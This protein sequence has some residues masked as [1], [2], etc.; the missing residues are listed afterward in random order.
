M[1][2]RVLSGILVTRGI[3]NGNTTI[4]FG[5]RTVTGSPGLEAARPTMV[6]DEGIY[7]HKPC[8]MV[9]IREIKIKETEYTRGKSKDDTSEI[10]FLRISTQK[11]DRE[12][13]SIRWDCS[14]GSEI[15]EIS[16]MIIG[17]V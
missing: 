6:G 3:P 14:G 15:E 8:H 4:N 13:L 9:A 12:E 11:I 1:G 5:A 7:E 17:N 10:D 2:I 16:Y